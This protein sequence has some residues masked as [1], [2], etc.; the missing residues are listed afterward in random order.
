MNTPRS[1]AS[2]RLLPVV[3]LLMWF[4]ASVPPAV[5][6]QSM[7]LEDFPEVDL[8]TI[9]ERHRLW[10]NEEV[11][12]I[13]TPK[14]REV[15]VR[16][17]SDEQRDKFIEAFWLQR[18]PTPG[19]PT[20]EYKIEHY[21]RF[22]Y[23]NE[24]YGR[25]T[26]TPGW[27][28]ARGQMYILLGP[29]QMVT[30][31]A[32]DMLTYPSETWFMAGDTRVGLPAYFY[33]MFYQRYGIGDYRLYS[34]AS[35]G[36]SKLLNAAGAREVEDRM[37]RQEQR[38]QLDPGFAPTG[39]ASDPSIAATYYTLREIDSDLANASISLFPS[40]AG[41]EFGITPLSSEMLLGDIQMVPERL[42]PDTR[43]ALDVLL[44][45]T[46]SIVRFEALE[47][48]V[49]ATPLLDI[50]G[51]PFL[52]FVSRATGNDLHMS[53]YEEQYY[54]AFDATGSVTAG[55][56]TVLQTFDQNITG[57]LDDDGARR[58]RDTDF[59]Y[60]DMVPT[61]PGEQTLEIVIENKVTR[62]F[63]RKTMHMRVPS[64]HPESVELLGPI[65]VLATR[66]EPDWD[67][68][69]ERLPFQYRGR[70]VIPSV[71]GQFFAGSEI[72]VLA[73]VLL[74][75]GFT[76]AL[77][78]RL[79][80]RNALGE[81]VME[82]TQ[83]I[84]SAIADDHGVIA[85]LLQIPTAGLG[86]GEYLLEMSLPEQGVGASASL[87]IVPPPSEP[88]RPFLNPQPAPPATDVMIYVERA[89]QYRESGDTGAAL[90]LLRDAA[91]RDPLNTDVVI[92]MVETLEAAGDY[93]ELVEL[94]T[95]E[96]ARNPRNT[97]AILRLARAHARLNQHYDAVRYY[98]R[99]RIAAGS[100]TTEVLNALAVE[101][102][103]EGK[104][105]KARELLTRSLEL[106]PDQPEIRRLLQSMA[107]AAEAQ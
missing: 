103:A 107:G 93:V 98:E 76:G 59:F 22:A 46:E 65:L 67:P 75:Q 11:Y 29:P 73:Q 78:L 17:S 61:I 82:A 49:Y 2:W 27:R 92:A 96:V 77:P 33:L 62:R 16:L 18:D 20:N 19:T 68:F 89:R 83:P 8:D 5:W 86:L 28:T 10:F 70:T 40:E 97:D 50:D 38:R 35:D 55:D 84:D 79:A 42:M 13:I 54:F 102:D 99:L 91:A 58:F 44:G 56:N 12:W 85:P 60:L 34:P 87:H 90:A 63:G 105:D 30:R 101:Y 7:S 43:Y 53:D 6:S 23:A 26:S 52:H 72:G 104:P 25:G 4:V 9:A 37:E 64:R 74:P 88:P 80:L 69:K 66:E 1:A 3:L 32:N 31:V 15:F 21:E 106:N 94:L 51:Q 36:P 100:D 14:E 41:L 81:V 24:F 48:D 39:F 71:N 95:P 47:I 45:I 57:E